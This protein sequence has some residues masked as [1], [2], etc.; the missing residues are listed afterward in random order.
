MC[1][2]ILFDQSIVKSVII[3][4]H[5]E[6]RNMIP[7]SSYA[8]GFC[9]VER[10]NLWFDV[11]NGSTIQHVHISDVESCSFNLDEAHD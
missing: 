10:G 8:L 1:H 4:R 7:E 5:V 2:P 9:K 11:E 3:I 6:F